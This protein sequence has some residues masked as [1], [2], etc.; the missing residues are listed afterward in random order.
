MHSQHSSQH[1]RVWAIGHDN[2]FAIQR[3]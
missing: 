2:R 3:I 1:A